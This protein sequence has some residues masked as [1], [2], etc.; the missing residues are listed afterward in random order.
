M[1]TVPPVDLPPLEAVGRLP[2]AVLAD[3]VRA[4]VREIWHERTAVLREVAERLERALAIASDPDAPLSQRERALGTAQEA[5]QQ[6]QNESTN[7]LAQAR[8]GAFEL[9]HSQST[10]LATTHKLQLDRD[11]SRELVPPGRWRD[12][13]NRI[14]EVGLELA[15]VRQD[16]QHTAQLQR[17]L[18]VD[19]LPRPAPG[20][21]LR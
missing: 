2:D 5:G 19:Y 1:L 7:V 6:L 11:L 3:R 18:E 10:S 15:D 17:E 14:P 21:G 20:G 8:E 13:L 12:L 4:Q 9:F 16:L